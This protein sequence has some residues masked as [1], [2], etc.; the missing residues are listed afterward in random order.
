MCKLCVKT[1]KT[2]SATLSWSDKFFI[3]FWWQFSQLI[4]MRN[5]HKL[6]WCWQWCLLMSSVTREDGLDRSCSLSEP[7]RCRCNEYKFNTKRRFSEK[8]TVFDNCYPPR[9]D[10]SENTSLLSVEPFLF[11]LSPL[12]QQLP[13]ILHGFIFIVIVFHFPFVDPP[14]PCVAIYIFLYIRLHNKGL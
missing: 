3:W 14:C 11:F 6:I 2:L 4:L 5:L 10:T 12:Y 9:D 8:L 7:Q 1:G 13:T